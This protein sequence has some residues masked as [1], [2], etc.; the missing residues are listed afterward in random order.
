MA[1]KIR[2]SLVNDYEVVV[3]GFN[4]MFQHY[5]DIEIVKLLANTEVKHS[6]DI[7]LYDSFGQ[8]QRHA[9]AVVDLVGNPAVDRVVIYTWTMSEHLI[10]WAKG[11]G[12]AGCLSK[13]MSARDLVA[14]LRRIHKGERVFSRLPTT[15]A[16]VAGDWP[17]RE[18]GLSYREAEMLSL[19]VQGL[20]NAE[21]AASLYL[22]PNSVKTY[23]RSAYRKI[24][25]T[26]RSQAVVWAMSRGFGIEKVRRDPPAN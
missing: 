11:M 15:N 19:L 3:L 10:S 4:Q 12:V 23:I 5:S 1:S 21:I 9:D 26:R 2:V 18:E 25:V 13:E 6:V 17:G 7:A 16:P 20:S 22:S 14:A 8:G 24:G